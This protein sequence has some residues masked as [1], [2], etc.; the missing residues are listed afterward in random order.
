[1]GQGLEN[2]RRTNILSACVEKMQ[3]NSCIL[4]MFVVV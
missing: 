3:K 4:E 1:M 2:I